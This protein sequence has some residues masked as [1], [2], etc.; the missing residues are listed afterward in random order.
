M[1]APGSP[2]LTF[3]LWIA[4]ILSRWRLAVAV[5]GATLA[6]AAVGVLLLPPVY[7]AHASFVTPSSAWRDVPSVATSDAADGSETPF[8]QQPVR[9]PG[10]YVKLL[11]SEELRR[12]LLDSRFRDPRGKSAQD[13]ATLLT[14][15]RI[16]N[17]DPR[18]AREIALRKLSKTTTLSFDPNSNLVGLV[19]RARSPE[20]AAAIA[21]RM[22][23]IVDSFSDEKRVILARSRRSFA[24]ARLAE[25]RA[26]L[27]R[28]ERI[29]SDF[30]VRNRVWQTSPDL[31]STEGSLRRN[32]QVARSLFLIHRA[33]FESARLQENDATTNI[34]VVDSAVAPRKAQWPRYGLLLSSALLSAMLLGL[35][36]SGLMTFL[37]AQRDQVAL[38]DRLVAASRESTLSRIGFPIF[39]WGLAFHSLIITGLFG[40]FALPLGKVRSIAA[41]KEVALLAFFLLITL[42]AL[43]GRGPRA[44]ISWADLWVGGL[45]VTAVL[46]LL[47]E[48]PWLRFDLPRQAE[49]LGIRD[50]VYFMLAYFVGRAMPEL[51]SKDTAMRRIFWLVVATSVI[52]VVERLLVTPEMLVALG[53]ASYFQDFLG[54]SAFTVGNDYGLPLNYWTRIGGELFRRA[55]SVY[56]SGQGFAV[57]FLLFFPLATTWVFLRTSRSR[58]QVGAY[59]LICTAL[60]LTLTRMTI[61]IAIIQL[62]T[63]ASL[64]RRPEW[65]VAGLAVAATVFVAAFTLIPGFPTFVWHTLSWQEG[66]SVSHLDDWVS[67]IGVFLQNPWGSG[68]GTADQTA[69]RSGLKHLTGDNLFLKYA[70][71]LGVLGLGFLLLALTT[72]ARSGMR[73][74]R[75]GA[76]VTEQRMGMTLWLATIGIALNGMT[77]VVFSSITLGWLF[78]WLAG[79]A[80]TVAQ[81]IPD[82]QPNSARPDLGAGGISPL[83]IRAL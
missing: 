29:Q 46:F 59:A 1:T 57:P 82:V 66:S 6:A 79:A 63:F 33:E 81:R 45:M 2:R 71:E 35:L 69:V 55:G 37:A 13:S 58:A 10:F 24:E 25:A 40:W 34:V 38:N 53:V 44:A 73:L 80:V 32:V 20:L 31:I 65:A 22:V 74:Y 49:L 17:D 12:R 11:E 39:A 77:A 68:L 15:L 30:H 64:R 50:A 61:L 70:V 3:S 42:R 41:W 76:S 67:G 7:R 14:I 47:V 4:G 5:A 23:E 36:A 9:P 19:V 43:T 78:F 51:A 56:L 75:H 83:G 16:R 8:A 54:V 62:M 48:N 72:I 21:N 26:A 18:R 60:M 52:G 28:A 27:R